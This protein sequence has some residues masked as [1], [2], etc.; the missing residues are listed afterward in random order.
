MTLFG[1]FPGNRGYKVMNKNAESV[2][3]H[4]LDE[5]LALVFQNVVNEITTLG[6]VRIEAIIRTVLLDAQGSWLRPQLVA[7][8]GREENTPT[9][10]TLVIAAVSEMVHC[11]SLLH[12]DVVDEG[13]T[14][15]GKPTANAHFGNAAAVLC[16]DVLMSQ[17]L[18]LLADKHRRRSCGPRT[19]RIVTQCP[20][21]RLPV[22]LS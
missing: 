21:T 19:M 9:Q 10:Q 20:G 11:A 15:R 6:E 7:A 1:I 8:I 14:R 2:P 18:D 12:D 4:N 3:N 16:G 5:R 22:P 17:A 13:F